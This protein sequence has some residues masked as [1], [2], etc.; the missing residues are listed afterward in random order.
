MLTVVII[1]SKSIIVFYL[2]GD[3]ICVCDDKSIKKF[4]LNLSFNE[5][6]DAFNLS[7][8]YDG[9]LVKVDDEH[10]AVKST[11]K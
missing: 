6:K 5:E 2:D 3:L 4:N 7:S 11:K 1:L 8:L 10:A 9:F